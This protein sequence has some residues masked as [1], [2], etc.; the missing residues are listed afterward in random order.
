MKQKSWH[1]NRRTF[2]RGAGISLALPFMNGMTVH[3]EEKA[4]KA[5]PKRTAY[6]FFPNGVSLPPK[7]NHQHED[8]YWFPK[9]VGK[10]YTFRKSQEALTPFKD[11]IS[12]IE[13]LSNPANREVN[14][15]TGPSGF[16]TCKRVEK[17]TRFNSISIDQ[18]IS[19]VLGRQTQLSALVLSTVGGVGS[20]RRTYTLSFD[21]KGKGIPA[22]SNLKDVYNRMYLSNSPEAKRKMARKTHLLN[23]V[24]A[25]AKDLKKKLGK[26]D[27]SSLDEYLSSVT[28]L[29]KKIENDRLWTAKNAVAIAPEMDLDV[30]IDDIER[31]IQTMYELIY[32]SFK[33]DITRQATY[34]LASESGTSPVVGLSKKIGISKDLHALSHSSPKGDSGYKKLGALGSVCC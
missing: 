6:I 20:M 33:A 11:E 16:L 22:L 1:L 18:Q 32:L 21:E 26:E 13:G 17:N 8:W 2:L 3:G 12:V 19:K 24:F 29:E 5:L 9:G 7:G 28:D 23:E 27:L 10:D 30:D 15:H 4:L 31:Y 25:D 34:Q 14:P